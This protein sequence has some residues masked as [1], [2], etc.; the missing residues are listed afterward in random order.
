MYKIKNILIQFISLILFLIILNGL[1]WILINYSL[2]FKQKEKNQWKGN[3]AFKNNN[4][5]ETL[6]EEND[7]IK[8]EYMPFTGWKHNEFKGKLIT[9][10]A[11]GERNFNNNIIDNNKPVIRLFGGSA[12]WGVGASDDETIPAYVGDSL[13]LFN[14]FNH[15]TQAYNSRQSL[16][17][18]IS[19]YE[20][21]EKS[22][23]VIFY[24]GV[25]EVSMCDK[26]TLI[27]GHYDT[28][29]FALKYLEQNDM[30]KKIWEDLIN[31][32]N[33]TFFRN[34]ISLTQKINKKLFHKKEIVNYFGDFVCDCDTIRTKRIAKMLI[35]NWE[36]THDLVSANGGVFFAFLQPV[37]AW[38][39]P[40]IDYLNLK[41]DP[42]KKKLHENLKV[43][44]SE[45][46][47]E[48]KARN[49]SW[50]VDVS[51]CLDSSNKYFID[52]CH[53]NGEGNKIIS[54]RILQIIRNR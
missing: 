48:I 40:N 43:L 27:P 10:N 4:F 28:N 11:N 35:K 8:F 49:L 25:N 24:D 42:E 19:L 32:L 29:S 47:K 1:S 14:I 34:T 37:S 16:D 17:K 54:K 33:G 20:L 31:G 46:S 6:W 23:I 52:Y 41:T 39:N 12:M 3:Q 45:V 9:T 18:L 50:I 15:G 30:T 36:I 7:A 53:L 2:F 38:Q 22:D 13:K 5:A 21:E 26:K 51:D 44:Y